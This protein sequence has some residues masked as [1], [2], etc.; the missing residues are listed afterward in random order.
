MKFSQLYSGSAG[1][2]YVLT[3]DSGQKIL[4]D[5]GVSWNKLKKALDYDLSEITCGLCSHEHQDHAKA[6][7][8]LMKAGINVYAT[9][10]TLIALRID[11]ERNAHAIQPMKKCELDGFSFVAI[12]IEHDAAQPCGFDIKDDQTEQF[13][14]FATDTAYIEILFTHKFSIVAL[15]CSYQIDLLK[16][17]VELESINE[18]LAQR[19]L[20]THMEFNTTLDYLKKLD[21]SRCHEIHLIHCS[22]T[23]LD[24]RKASRQIESELFIDVVTRY[25]KKEPVK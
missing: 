16:K 2:S 4:I 12:P 10:G 9:N 14:F 21:L 8:D 6:V 25:S 3:L 24:I 7:V 11:Q 19:L 17:H 20:D 18:R 1:N 23:N 5:P 13:C 22:A 15:E